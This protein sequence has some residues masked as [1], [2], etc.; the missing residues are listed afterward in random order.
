MTNKSR[1]YSMYLASIACFG[2]SVPNGE[3]TMSIIVACLSAKKYSTKNTF[4]TTNNKIINHNQ[5]K[6]R[7]KI[8]LVSLTFHLE[9]ISADHFGEHFPQRVDHIRRCVN[10]IQVVASCWFCC[11]I[12]GLGGRGTAEDEE[13]QIVQFNGKGTY[14]CFYLCVRTNMELYKPPL[15]L[16]VKKGVKK[17]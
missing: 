11:Q 15:H 4:I 13:L 12:L 2:S 17:G 3:P 5:N 16:R 1:K 9:A 14:L 7:K 8:P 6:I 10:Q